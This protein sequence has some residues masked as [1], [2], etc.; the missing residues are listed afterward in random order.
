MQRTDQQR[1]IDSTIILVFKMCS[2]RWIVDPSIKNRSFD[3]RDDRYFFLV[4]LL[5]YRQ[6]IVCLMFSF[7][8]LFG[9]FTR[10]TMP[11]RIHWRMCIMLSWFT[12]SSKVGSFVSRSYFTT[13]VLH[14]ASSCCY[15]TNTRAGDRIRWEKHFASLEQR[16]DGC[17]FSDLRHFWAYVIEIK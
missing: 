16:I 13:R 8:F 15:S 2:M 1:T 7:H 3:R 9:T 17:T 5:T 11:W 12:F 14:C 10:R 6:L 4:L